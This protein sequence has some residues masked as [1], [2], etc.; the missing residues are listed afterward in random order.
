MDRIALAIEL[1]NVSV[2]C[3]NR[4]LSKQ[5]GELMRE[6]QRLRRQNRRIMR[7]NNVLTQEVEQLCDLVEVCEYHLDSLDSVHQESVEQKTYIKYLERQIKKLI[8][9]K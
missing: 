8:G 3:E 6:V 7:R 4:K 5:V 9:F 2:N 1:V